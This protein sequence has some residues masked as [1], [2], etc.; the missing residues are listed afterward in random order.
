MMLFQALS[1]KFAE[2]INADTILTDQQKSIAKL[3]IFKKINNFVVAT[4]KTSEIK[5]KENIIKF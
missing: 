5:D 2:L 1:E 3:M 4:A